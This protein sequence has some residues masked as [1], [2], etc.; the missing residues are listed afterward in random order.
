MEKPETEQQQE[1]E[2]EVEN[3]DEEEED[4]ADVQSFVTAQESEKDDLVDSVNDLH[5]GHDDDG[6]QFSFEIILLNILSIKVGSLH[7]MLKL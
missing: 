6:N 3:N 4:N 5:L 2:D 7:R 1:E